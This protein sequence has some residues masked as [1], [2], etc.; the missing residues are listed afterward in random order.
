MIDVYRPT[1]PQGKS[2]EKE[3]DTKDRYE[4]RKC[5]TSD[6]LDR[7]GRRYFCHNCKNTVKKG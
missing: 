6:F 7:N 2:S 4:C 1:T 5:K 3:H